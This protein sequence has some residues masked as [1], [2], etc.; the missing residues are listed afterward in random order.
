MAFFCFN[1]EECITLRIFIGWLALLAFFS[2]RLFSG[3]FY[4]F[5]WVDVSFSLRVE[6]LLSLSA[7]N[8]VRCSSEAK[9]FIFFLFL[10]FLDQAG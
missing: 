3:Y 9:V 5:P 10:F 4:F 8:L 2:G 1:A 6:V 7:E